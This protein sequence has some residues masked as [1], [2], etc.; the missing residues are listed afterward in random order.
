MSDAF[1]TIARIA[2]VV[3]AAASL[4]SRA[5][6]QETT[7]EQLRDL[8]ELRQEVDRRR[9]ELRRELTLLKEVLGEEPD[10]GLI[11]LAGGTLGMTPDELSAELRILRED[12][13]RLREQVQRERLT[14]QE[15][16]YEVTGVVR[17][18]LEWSDTDFASG[19]ADLRQLLRS[20]LL[21]TGRPRHDTRVFVELQDGRSWGEEV[22]GDGSDAAADAFDLHQGYVELREIYGQ[23]LRLRLGRQE[24]A[25]GSYRLMGPAEWGNTGRAFDAIAVRVGE[26][27]WADAFVAKLAEKGV[28]DR[29]LFGLQSRFEVAVGHAVGPYLMLEQD[30]NA[31]AERMLRATGGT[32]FEG[33]VA[34][35]TGHLF[36]YDL[37]GAAQVGEVG[38]QDVRA[39]MATATVRYRGPSW[40]QPELRLGVD[41]MSGDPDPTGG[42]GE[43][44]DNLYAS[45]HRFFGLMD[46][47]LN[48]PEDTGGR[49][50]I[51]FRLS[52]E[53][54]AAQS[55][56][57]GL[58]V[59]HFALAQAAAGETN[60]GEEADAVVSYDHN[61]VATLHWGGSVFVPA[62]GMKARSGGED[63][64]VK[65]WMQLSVR[66]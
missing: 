25:Y 63:L 45:R 58:H 52:G 20:R 32:R 64:A 38:T 13:D 23:S 36:G 7:A 60:L 62:D 66:F 2:L 41:A 44:F 49:G 50:L 26:T 14:A 19:R 34:G 65:S 11:S 39:W 17:S 12:L 59:H 6:A 22:G 28:R 53:M 43:A 4:A 29:N 40:S 21:V 33:A 15:A 54:S 10:P 30:K 48:V 27:S 51:D 35:S 16:K 9:S 5:A 47:F 61:E 46:L 18:R 57:V 24:L 31:G 8:Q 37:E 3:A 55:V 42:D 1:R 56:R